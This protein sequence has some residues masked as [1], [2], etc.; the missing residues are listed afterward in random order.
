MNEM[1]AIGPLWRELAAAG[2]EYVLATIV[3]VEG[4]GYRKSGAKMIV[5]ADGRRAG[6]IS[7]GCLEAEVAKKA[8]WHTENGPTKR[9]YSTHAEDGDVPYGMGCGGVVHVLL[10]RSATA[11]PLLQAMEQAYRSRVGMAVATV[12]VGE[13][14]GERRWRVDGT[15]PTGAERADSLTSLAF[16]AFELKQ[17]RWTG[18]V[19]V[20]W[21]APRTGLLIVGAG[22]DT[23]PL[24]RMAHELG[25]HVT[26]MD[27]RSHLATR[28]RFPQ[29]DAVLPLS[30]DALQELTLRPT[31]VAAV[32]S[33]S[34]EQDTRALRGLVDRELAYLGVLGPR[35]RTEEMVKGLAEATQNEEKAARRL[36]TKWMVQLHAPMGL[37]L[38]GDGAA[39]V[40]L[41]ILAEMQQKL[42]QRSGQ[43]LRETRANAHRTV[44]QEAPMEHATVLG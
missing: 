25:W 41:S 1:Q 44:A 15:M 38:G 16:E 28:E 26:V 5:A 33:H 11:E 30:E 6:T 13:R 31:D 42:Q 43:P 20:E 29:S 34:L 7:G 17:T 4:S 40:A 21:V 14:M 8:F 2:E 9:S 39:A 32:M 3:A 24:A 36:A 23:Q 22:N 27:G 10:E 35:T 18:D 19:F 37:D 12:T